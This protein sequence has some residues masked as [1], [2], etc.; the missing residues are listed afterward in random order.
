MRAKTAMLHKHIAGM[1]V[2]QYMF[3]TSFYTLDINVYTHF[4][5]SKVWQQSQY[6]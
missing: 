3:N 4:K 6:Y 2:S 5:S 1:P